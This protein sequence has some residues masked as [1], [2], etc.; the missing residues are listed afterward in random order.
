MNSQPFQTPPKWWPSR[1]SPRLIRLVRSFRLRDLKQKGICSID[2]LG[3]EAIRN[4]LDAGAGVL[5][6]PNHSFHY[7]SYV[8]IE[9]ALQAGWHTH[10]MTAWQVFGMSTTPGKHFLQRHGCFSIN[11]EGTDTKAIKQA[12][13]ILSEDQHALTVFSEGDIYH[14]NDRVMPFR[15]GAAAIA[16]KAAKRSGRPIHVYP[17]GMKCFYTQDPTDELVGMMNQLEERIRW[18]PRPDLPLLDRIYRFGHGFLSSKE[19]EYLG[20]SGTGDLPARLRFL[21][22]NILEKVRSAHG[23][24]QRS[25]DITEQIR[26][27]RSYLIREIEKAQNS[28]SDDSSNSE[29]AEHI[30]TLQRHLDDMFFVTQLTSYH[31]NYTVENPTIERMAETIDKFE[32]DI[33]DLQCPT[34]RGKRR[35][36]VRFGEP[37]DLSQAQLDTSSLT[38][39]A[40]ANVQKLLNEINSEQT[41]KKIAS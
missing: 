12:I 38:A 13:S 29:I 31:G 4:S 23:L 34:S 11:R 21:A 37:I 9:A 22:E 7:D 10:F 30:A 3:A 28:V 35:A 27:I 17:C 36:V 8:L 26:G 33:F 20:E 1:L 41:V 24:K 25:Q 40:E 18:R 32:E 15:E 39:L 2:V 16:L 6:L 14:S 19:I 5:L